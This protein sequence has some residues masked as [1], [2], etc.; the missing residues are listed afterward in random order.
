MQA[1]PRTTLG[2][3]LTFA[4]RRIVGDAVWVAISSGVSAVIALVNVRIVSRMCDAA[5]YGEASLVLGI[6]TL[7]SGLVLGPLSMTHLRLIY[8]YRARSMSAWFGGA[9]GRLFRWSA[10]AC[11][12]VYATI[13]VIS[14][15]T[16]GVIYRRH[17]V[18][19]VLLL[20]VSPQLSMIQN[21]NESVRNQRSLA[22]INILQQLSG[23]CGT[24]LLLRAGVPGGYAIVYS[25]LVAMV[26]PILLFGKK[27]VV[28]KEASI[29][30]DPTQQLVEG[31]RL[32]STVV[33][34]G[35]SV[36]AGRI[37]AWVASTSDRYLVE[38]FLSLE[39][40]GVYTLNYG[41][42]SKPYLVLT[43]I[44]EIASRPIIYQRAA[45]GKWSEVRRIIRIRLLV[46]VAVCL[47]VT[48]VLYL[49]TGWLSSIILSPG[50]DVGKGLVAWLLIGHV[51]FFV[52]N[53]FMSVFLAKNHGHVP[54]IATSVSAVAN[55]LANLVLIPRYGLTGA[56]AAT[57]VSYAI[58]AVIMALV[59][60]R[61]L[62]QNCAAERASQQIAEPAVSGST[63]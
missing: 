45:D 18:G 12:T 47:V 54:L 2:R 16:G 8:E 42:W 15:V 5:S 62:A 30:V 46:S 23:V 33:T 53:T 57:A 29:E 27:P 36:A 40:V 9:F 3:A 61:F 63:G 43:G 50:Y 10:V 24:V 31:R 39:R 22:G 28:E 49:L 4:K 6:V 59:A 48:P 44:F 7:I 35:W 26:L 55:A 32:R 51:F 41:L 37:A 13:A 25:Q 19:A 21:R 58:F 20:L 1:D 17:L 38:M 56:A 52:G 14:S 11:A 60:E 34:Y